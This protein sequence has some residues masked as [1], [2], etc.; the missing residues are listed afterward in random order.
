MKNI[1]VF[2]GFIFFGLITTS[3]AQVWRL[4]NIPGVDADFTT[5]LQNAVD[6]V[7]DGDTIYVE[8]SSD[9]YGDAI[10]TK[11]VILIGSGYLKNYNDSTQANLSDSRVGE[12]YFS[13]GSQGSKVSGLK[14]YGQYTADDRYYFL[15]EI[16]TDSITIQKNYIYANM[17]SCNW[18]QGDCHGYVI[19]LIG[20]R[21]DVT[22]Q[23]NL[24]RSSVVGATGTHNY[25]IRLHTGP[26]E[27]VIIR[28]NILKSV[29]SVNNWAI[30]EQ[31]SHP[32]TGVTINNN[33]IVGSVNTYNTLHIN[34]IIISGSF[35]N[36]TGLSANNLSNSDQYPDENNNQQNIT[37][38]DVFINYSSNIDNDF[39]L[40]SGSP[41]IDAGYNGG[42]C[43][44]FGNG[45]GGYPYVLSGMPA[46]PSIFEAD[47]SPTVFPGDTSSVQVDI[48]VKS[49]R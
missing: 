13:S 20:S 39:I 45:F 12:L 48:K 31:N 47:F 21:K 26:Y 5:T 17:S 8:P 43:G 49:N 40:K 4:N 25:A 11:K 15:I 33:V 37:M 14:I 19:N 16:N 28:N 27:N 7:S 6:S 1:T 23:Q 41:A 38:N 32:N 30:N 35:F 10:I 24:I 9:G 36:Q 42:D 18:G 46:I 3:N 44:I 34:N 29:N 2:F 22:I